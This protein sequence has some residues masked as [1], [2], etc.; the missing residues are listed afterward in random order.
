MA[1]YRLPSMRPDVDQVSSEA[2]P[3]AR[4]GPPRLEGRGGWNQRAVDRDRPP[5]GETF[6]D[7]VI[8]ADAVEPA[9]VKAKPTG[10]ASAGSPASYA[11]DG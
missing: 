9:I 2:P 11:L 7:V 4:T 10:Q 5:I 8:D 6:A 1:K 3:G